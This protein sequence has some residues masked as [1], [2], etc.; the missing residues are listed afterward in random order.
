MDS[1]EKKPGLREYILALVILAVLEA[2]I[3][4]TSIASVFIFVLIPSCLTYIF[5]RFDLKWSILPIILTV[6]IPSLVTW[7]LNMGT[8][9]A[10]VP[11]AVMLAL[12][13]KKKKTPLYIV[14]C[15][16]LGEIISAVVVVIILAT[17][18]EE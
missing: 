2:G 16:V 11:M 4:A 14:G 8:F 10:C 17:W 15:G 9:I 1:I 6:L 7:G 5:V 3:A 13:I 18:K 12:A